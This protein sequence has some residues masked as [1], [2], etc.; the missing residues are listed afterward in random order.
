MFSP[1]ELIGSILLKKHK[2]RILTPLY[3]N[4]LF[5]IDN[6]HTPNISHNNLCDSCKIVLLP[7]YEFSYSRTKCKVFTIQSHP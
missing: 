7:I 6:T 5:K 3:Y 4:L 1:A 2:E